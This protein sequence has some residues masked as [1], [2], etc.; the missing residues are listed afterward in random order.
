MHH[1][2]VCLIFGNHIWFTAQKLT[3]IIHYFQI[4]GGKS[5]VLSIHEKTFNKIPHPF[6]KKTSFQ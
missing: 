3:S 1:N 2:H 5:M 6:L 4:V